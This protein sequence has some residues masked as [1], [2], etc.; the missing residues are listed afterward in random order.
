MNMIWNVVLL[1]SSL[2]VSVG[3]NGAVAHAAETPAMSNPF[4][5]DQVATNFV[6]DFDATAVQDPSIPVLDFAQSG[7]SAEKSGEAALFDAG[8]TAIDA[9]DWD[10]AVVKFEKAAAL[11]GQHAPESLYWEA[12]AYKKLGRRSEAL[13][14][15][16]ELRKKYPKSKWVD[17]AR[18]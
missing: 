3:D 8:R 13:N 12:Y 9:E 2:L 4:V 5:A 17:D 18:A 10:T 7:K 11:N 1:S 14:C 6:S 15:L 16:S